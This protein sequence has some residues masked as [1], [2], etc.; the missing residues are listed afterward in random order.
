[1]FAEQRMLN[2][3]GKIWLPRLQC[4]DDALGDAQEVIETYYDIGYLSE[5]EL[6]LH[7]LY[8]ATSTVTAKLMECP[9]K[10][11]ND[12]QMK[13]YHIY[14]QSPFYFLRV[15]SQFVGRRPEKSEANARRQRSTAPVA[16]S[17]ASST[18]GDS[19]QSSQKSSE[20]SSSKKRGRPLKTDVAAAAVSSRPSRNQKK[21]RL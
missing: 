18:D 2:H 15:K 13:P 8:R 20:S 4:I 3:E 7:P 10:L 17:E 9:D 5:E 14:S 1:M 6:D 11:T 12:T 16:M 21:T 19:E